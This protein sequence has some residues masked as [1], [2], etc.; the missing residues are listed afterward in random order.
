MPP[1]FVGDHP[2]VAADRSMRPTST[3]W[4]AA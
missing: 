3:P 4:R 2:P 1:R